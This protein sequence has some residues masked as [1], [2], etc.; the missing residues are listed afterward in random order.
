MNI[1]T[2]NKIFAFILPA[3]LLLLSSCGDFLE[4]SSQDTDYV[5][6]WSDLNELLIGSCYMPVNTTSHYSSQPTSNASWGTG[7]YGMLLHLVGDEVQEVT[8]KGQHDEFESHYREFGAYTW[9]QFIG[10]N[11][12]YT[13]T[14]T[15]NYEWQKAYNAINVANNVL[16]SLD[17]VPQRSD[18][19]QQGALKVAGEA[20]FL[21]GWYYFWL[22][23]LYGKP[24]DPATASSAP[25][26]P[27]KTSAEVQD[28]VY[29]RQSVQQVYDQVLSDLHAAEA[30]LSQYRTVKKSIYRADSTAVCLLLS[31]VYLYMQNWPKAAEYARKVIAHHPA[32]QNMNTTTAAFMQASNVE[33]IFSMGGD[34]VTAM[35][36]PGAGGLQVSNSLYNSY[37]N[38]DRRK[39]QWF[40]TYG[41][42]LGLTKQPTGSHYEAVPPTNDLYYYYMFYAGRLGYQSEVSSLFW[43]RSAEAYLN[44]AEAE[45][46][47]GNDAAART[48]LLTLMQNR[49]NNNAAELDLSATSGSAL[50]TLIRE[51]RRREFAL[52]G[53]RWFDLRR[54]RVCTV[55]PSKTSITHDFTYYANHT[56]VTPVETRRYV[57]TKDDASWTLPI[58]HEVL[59]YNTGME[60][61]GN[62]WRTFTTIRNY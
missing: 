38:D 32:L 53:H 14:Y 11:E 31:R 40:W 50:I 25:G 20:H 30:E 57:L 60:G 9:Q 48:A 42:F 58:P 13:D 10:Q 5:R 59:E 56:S 41:T 28:I 52:E 47:Q 24:Y 33:N 19:E 7:N 55:Q 62:Q 37:A 39:S 45:A 22:V 15:E 29:T 36:M 16:S 2:T 27:I 23:N 34:D 18:E 4:E 6:S 26:V 21:R 61:N 54:Y 44:L 1:M 35:L 8:A 17:D 46:Y 43:L 51:E 12:T 49:Y 3:M